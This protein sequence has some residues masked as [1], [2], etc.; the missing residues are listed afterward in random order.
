MIY[1]SDTLPIIKELFE[2]RYNII[3]DMLG[4]AS[5]EVSLIKKGKRH[6]PFDCEFTYSRL[7]DPNNEMSLAYIKYAEEESSFRYESNENRE[8]R[9]K[10]KRKNW[11]K[12]L[13]SVLRTIIEN[14]YPGVKKD[15]EDCWGEEKYKDFVLEL[16]RRTRQVE[17]INSKLNRSDNSGKVVF[18]PEA[19]MKDSPQTGAETAQVD[20]VV[21]SSQA[22]NKWNKLLAPPTKVRMPDEFCERFEEFKIADFIK[23][24][25]IDLIMENYITAKGKHDGTELI[26]NA[27]RFVMHMEEAMKHMEISESNEHFCNEVNVFISVLREYVSF[28]LTDINTDVSPYLID[29]PIPYEEESNRKAYIGEFE[30][31]ATEYRNKLQSQFEK[32]DDYIIHLEQFTMYTG[33]HGPKYKLKEL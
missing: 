23:L 12:H 14:K 27:K 7:F 11:E 31:K 6:F 15:L 17:P 33:Y 18:T 25:P 8:S 24:N 19:P 20:D 32:I 22:L 30:R 10:K 21:L 28:L 5:K 13:L 29:I 16:L 3:A 9:Q 2:T 26:N 4:I 1:W